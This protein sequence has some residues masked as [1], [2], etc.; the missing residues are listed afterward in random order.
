MPKNSK[1]FISIYLMVN[2]MEDEELTEEEKK[3]KEE[4]D[5][6]IEGTADF[7]DTDEE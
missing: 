5:K 6:L 1:Y 4:E 2:K 7:P 3:K